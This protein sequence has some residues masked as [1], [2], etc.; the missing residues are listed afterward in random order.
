MKYRKAIART[1]Q[2]APTSYWMRQ[3]SLI[4]GAGMGMT[5]AVQAQRGVVASKLRPQ[6]APRQTNVSRTKRRD[7]SP[8]DPAFSAS[9]FP[10]PPFPA[11]ALMV[12]ALLV[13]AIPAV[14]GQ[15]A[16]PAGGQ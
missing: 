2:S 5:I 4:R 11:M 9:A 15:D 10:A 7:G 16:T 14:Y 12:A 8:S 1:L 3:M 13:A 6:D